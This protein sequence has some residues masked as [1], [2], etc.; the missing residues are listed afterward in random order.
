MVGDQNQL[1]ATI[2]S[3][4]AKRAGYDRSLFE[5]LVQAG[6]PN[7]MLDTQYRMNPL[8]RYVVFFIHKFFLYILKYIDICINMSNIFNMI[9]IY[10]YINTLNPY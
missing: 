4:K 6:Y 1:P 3:D 7:I 8:I 2:F 9:C 5:R 10:S